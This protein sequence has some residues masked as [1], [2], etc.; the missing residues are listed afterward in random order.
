[1]ASNKVAVTIEAGLLAQVDQLV[2]K[3]VFPNRS[4][5]IQEALRDKLDRLRRTRLARE[6]AK[7]DRSEEQSLADE[8]IDR[9]LA[10][11]PKY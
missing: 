11:W 1:M 5:A 10:E 4:Q 7:L 8:G 9:E 2:A 6:C 3:Q